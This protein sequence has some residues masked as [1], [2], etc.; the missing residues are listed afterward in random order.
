[1]A[2]EFAFKLPIHGQRHDEPFATVLELAQVAEQGGFSALYVIDHLLLPADRLG[3]RTRADLSKPYF[4]DAWTTLAAVAART[5]TIRIGPQVT[6]IGLRH[7]VFIAKWG[8][9][10][11][12]ISNGRLRLG[13]G[14]GHQEIEYVSHGFPYPPFRQRF[15]AMTEGVEIIRALWTSPDPVTYEGKY[16]SIKDVS[17]WPKPVQP[18][19][20]IWY[21]GTSKSIREGVAKLGDGWFPAAPQ[22]G[23]FTATFYKDSLAAI[24]ADAAERGRTERIGSGILLLTAVAETTDELDRAT[25]LLQRRPEFA[26]LS[27]QE[28]MDKGVIFMG[29]PDDI[30]RQLEPF[31]ESGVE[32][33]T[34]GLHPLDDIDGIRR[35]L[36]LYAEKILPRFI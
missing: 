5:K 28:L 33:I 27:A 6:P 31:V 35:A 34:I 1:M 24:R 8:A 9:T 13:V 4:L 18:R 25:E 23:G 17:F 12:R 10:V 2:T 15:E 20:E 21:G 3:G 16:Y 19:V 22:L 29:T 14:L 32:E 26:Q 11:D 30:C 36:D 7:P